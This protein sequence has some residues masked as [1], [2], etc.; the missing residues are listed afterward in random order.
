MREREHFYR[1]TGEASHLSTIGGAVGTLE[2][3]TKQV[4]LRV[5]GFSGLLIVKRPRDKFGSLRFCHVDSTLDPEDTEDRSDAPFERRLDSDRENEP[6]KKQVKVSA[7][8]GGDVLRAVWRGAAKRLLQRARPVRFKC[9]L[10]GSAS[11]RLEGT[12]FTRQACRRCCC[13]CCC[14]RC[15]CRCC[16]RCCCCSRGSLGRRSL[17]LPC[18]PRAVPRPR[19]VCQATPPLP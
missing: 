12:R 19:A 11:C 18:A 5:V 13:R 7:P 8:R 4:G 6:R 16:Y 2:L 9:K 14:C 3:L 1:H 10:R 17:A 15:C